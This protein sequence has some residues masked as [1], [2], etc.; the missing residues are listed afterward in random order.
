MGRIPFNNLASKKIFES[1]NY[2]IS[3]PG[4]NFDP[5]YYLLFKYEA[6]SKINFALNDDK[7]YEGNLKEIVIPLFKKFIKLNLENN[8]NMRELNF[9]EKGESTIEY[10]DKLSFDEFNFSKSNGHSYLPDM[11]LNKISSFK[12][13]ANE[14]FDCDDFEFSDSE[15]K[16]S[17]LSE[18]TIQVQLL[19]SILL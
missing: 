11:N 3:V 4:F 14:I 16:K 17:F 2:G 13:Y 15:S 12:K 5:Y 19:D 8:E 1:S 7:K 9:P 10:L 6:L 18:V